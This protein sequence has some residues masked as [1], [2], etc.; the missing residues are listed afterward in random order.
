MLPSGYKVATLTEPPQGHGRIERP[1]HPAS[2]ASII[3]YIGYIASKTCA[4][5][6]RKVIFFILL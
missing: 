2:H 3:Y 4:K 5:L 1:S 6:S